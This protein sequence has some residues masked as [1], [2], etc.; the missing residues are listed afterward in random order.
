MTKLGLPVPPGFTLS[1]EIC[2][3]FY[4]NNRTY[5]KL[6]EVQVKD[7]LKKMERVMGREFG[8]RK[9]PLLVSVRSGARASMPGMMD[10]ILNLGLNNETIE[11]MIEDTK[12]PRFCWD[13]YRRFIAMYS[14]VVLGIHTNNFEAALEDLKHARGV[15]LDTDLSAEDLKELVTTYK[16]LVRMQGKVFPEQPMAQLWGAVGAVFGSWMS[17]R[18]ITYRRLNSI[19]E[20]WG[21]A[22]NVQAM[23]FGNM[24]DDCATGV[25]FTRDPSTGAKKFFGEFLINAQGE[26]VV[27]GIRTPQ[28]INESS[29]QDD[30]E[31]AKLVT[32]E[33][34]MPKAYK[35]LVQVY[36]K[37]EK[38]YRD[39]QDIEFTIERG[40]LFMLQTR[41]GKRTAAAAVKIAVDMV[42]E[43][44]ISKNEAIMRVTPDQVDQLLH[45]C[46]DPTATKKVLAKGLPASPG[47][48]AGQIVFDPDVAEKWVNEQG[49]KVILV[50]VETSPEDIHGMSVAQGILTARGGMTSH[51]AVVARGMG[52]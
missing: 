43:R 29:R 42:R 17:P 48:A 15:E 24:G 49:K 37:L 27:A 12:N 19:P 32:L 21:T 34:A 13:S 22:V 45:P 4:A 20:D 14:D 44:L 8:G 9:L 46:L 7:A 23:V 52:K 18:A 36:Q 5:P 11:G 10:T 6:L 50:R 38:H 51:A 30:P 39:M 28:P 31:S 2:T 40:K 35:E 1:T 41:N 47:A 16:N 3:Y 26:D 33:K 25:A